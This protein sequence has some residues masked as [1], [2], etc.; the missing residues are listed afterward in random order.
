MPRSSQYGLLHSA[1]LKNFFSHRI[2]AHAG[3]AHGT[4]GNITFGEKDSEATLK[5][6]KLARAKDEP[7][8]S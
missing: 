7:T 5:R 1:A 2:T 8:L 3:T 4:S 6:S